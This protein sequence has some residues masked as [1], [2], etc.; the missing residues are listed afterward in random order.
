[1]QIFSSKLLVLTSNVTVGDPG[2]RQSMLGIRAKLLVG[3]HVWSMQSAFL[4]RVSFC[5]S[6]LIQLQQSYGQQLW[7]CCI[8]HP[9]PQH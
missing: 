7:E 5:W 2:M 4:G 9:P 8:G 6:L 1:M 3:A